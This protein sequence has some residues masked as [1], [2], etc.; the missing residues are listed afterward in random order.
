VRK[1]DGQNALEKNRNGP[2][3]R[4]EDKVVA[5]RTDGQEAS[6]GPAAAPE[7]QAVKLVARRGAGGPEPVANAAVRRRLR[8]HVGDRV[9]RRSNISRVL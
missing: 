9:L 2:A 8:K 3:P 5:P 7:R 6:D 1:S 4:Q